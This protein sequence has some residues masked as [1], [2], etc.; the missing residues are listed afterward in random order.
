[1]SKWVVILASSLAIGIFGLGG[2]AIGTAG[3]AQ[4]LFCLF[5][6][7][8]VAFMLIGFLSIDLLD[9]KQPDRREDRREPRGRSMRWSPRKV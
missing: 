8:F 9:R 3:V 1:M 4:T 7:L 2:V 6:T 5:L